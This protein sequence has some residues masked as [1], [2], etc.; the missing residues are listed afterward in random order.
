M[1]LPL[2]LL[3]H[4]SSPCSPLGIFC[5]YYGCCCAHSRKGTRPHPAW[6]RLL[7]HWRLRSL[8]TVQLAAAGDAAA[9]ASY[10]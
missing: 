10:A 1:P 9:A 6:Q 3:L 7:L 4:C 5:P 2:L 8:L